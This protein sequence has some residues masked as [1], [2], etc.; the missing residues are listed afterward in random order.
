MVK[1]K[2]RVIKLRVATV[3]L[4]IIF[5]LSIG[6]HYLEA[7]SQTIAYS[8]IESFLKAKKFEK[9]LI[10]AKKEIADFSIKG[11]I[12]FQEINLFRRYYRLKDEEELLINLRTFLS[13]D[14]QKKEFY[15]RIAVNQLSQLK[16]SQSLLYLD[17]LTTQESYKNDSETQSKVLS[18]KTI[19]YSDLGLFIVSNEWGIKAL[20]LL[21]QRKDSMGYY[22]LTQTIAYNDVQ[23]R[24]FDKALRYFNQSAA[25][26]KRTEKKENLINNYL[27][28]GDLF[29]SMNR[30]PDAERSF[31]LALELAKSRN[32][33]D[34]QILS[35][36]YLGIVTQ[37]DGDFQ[38]AQQYMLQAENLVKENKL[39]SEE[40]Q[41]KHTR[42][43]IE[44]EAKNWQ[45]AGN[46]MNWI[47][48][49]NASNV[50]ELRVP[51]ISRLRYLI[52]QNKI[53]EANIELEKEEKESIY[54]L[55]PVLEEW[56]RIWIR[57]LQNP[58]E[59]AVLL[60]KVLENESIQKNKALGSDY[61]KALLSAINSGILK[62]AV[63]PIF[64][65]TQNT[66][67]LFK[68]NE[69]IKGVL[70]SNR[71]GKN[72]QIESI[73]S[74]SLKLMARQL[75]EQISLMK[76][77]N[78]GIDEIQFSEQK[79]TTIYEDLKKWQASSSTDEKISLMNSDDAQRELSEN[80]LF[81][82]VL[83]TGN[84]YQI[85]LLTQEKI[86][87]RVLKN[88]KEIQEQVQQL[89]DNCK[90]P[91]EKWNSTLSENL[92]ELIFPSNEIEIENFDELTISADGIW[93]AFPFETLIKSG[94]YLAETHKI[95]YISSFA[96]AK[97]LDKLQNKTQSDEILVFSNPEYPETSSWQSLTFS[98]LE[99]ESIIK[100]WDKV[101]LFSASEAT[102]SNFKNELKKSNYSIIH[103]ASHGHMDKTPDKNRLIF[104]YKTDESTA[105][106]FPHSLSSNSI[107]TKLVVLS[108]CETAAGQYIGG[109]G[110]WGM[111]RS[112]MNAGAESVLAGLW[113]VNDKSTALFMDS[114][115]RNL[116]EQDSWINHKILDFFSSEL[117]FSERA[118]SVYEA[119]KS[120]ILNQEFSHPYYWAGLMYFGL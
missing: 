114:F 29:W 94:K 80:Q 92:S 31:L 115:Y 21:I 57:G 84:S 106:F 49:A 69:F 25:Y 5:L 38:K 116:K 40:S 30:V 52:S 43:L 87:H 63:E 7:Q 47:D 22:D 77:S 91:R 46:L 6:C 19:I 112:W 88:K 24:N 74:D 96:V 118:K 82:H 13:A 4:S 85:L 108:A 41:I 37:T 39:K 120:M 100:N 105:F 68:V 107:H 9:A 61:H 34:L 101:R 111:Q 93:T 75:Q 8:K 72:N 33:L 99:A 56:F 90:N 76:L 51:K 54:P 2:F 86:V 53:N 60:E 59:A 11:I 32:Q 36:R 26:Y 109:E 12:P 104:S 35:L 50:P 48:S 1:S 14:D 95:R 102:I 78:K 15:L 66:A 81:I 17:S 117:S 28:V 3:Y 89:I 58:K 113:Q 71:L 103:I 44:I 45:E 119:K 65:S 42:M 23:L 79:L 64:N 73:E 18:Y 83:E 62:E 10:Y 98:K 70:L 16:Y 27:N 55:N 110:I 20:D 97:G 67:L